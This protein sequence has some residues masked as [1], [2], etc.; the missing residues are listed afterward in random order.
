M[1]KNDDNYTFPFNKKNHALLIAEKPD[2][3]R[4]IEEVYNDH[5]SEISYKISFVSQRGHLLTLLSPDEMDE[6]Q[7]NW[8]WETLPF[9]PEEHGGWKYKVIKEKKTGSFLTSQERF[10]IIKKELSSGKY[11][12][13]INAGD[14]DQ[15]G[16]LL[17][18]IVLSQAENKLPVMRF[19]T[20]DLTESHI[21]NALKNLKNDDKDPMLI[22]LI[23]AAYGRQHSDYRVGMNISRAAT[24][25]MN[26]RVACGRVKTP[27]LAIVCRREDEIENFVP[28][29]SYGVMAYYEDGIT[30]S[31]YDPGASDEEETEDKKGI[32]WFD[33]KKDAENIISKLSKKAKVIFFE[34]KE[35]KTYAPKQFKLATLQIEAGKHGFSDGNTL[36]IVQRLYEKRLLSY[37]RTD[38]EYLSSDENFMGIL[39]VMR[40]IGT[41]GDFVKTIT[42]GDLDRVKKSDKW[43][44]D[45]ALEESGHSAI[46]PTTTVP[47]YSEL[48]ADE[49]YIYEMV[50]KR[51][52]SMF[53]PPLIQ[54]KTTLIT[55]IDGYQFR[56]TGKRLIDIGFEKIFGTSFTDSIMPYKQVDDEM[57]VNEF[58]VS[59]KKLQC[60]KHLT[61]PEIIA[62]CE[63]PAKYLHDKSLKKSL[64]KNLKLGTPATR[65]PIIEQLIE[66]DKYLEVKRE[67]KRDV[68]VPTTLGRMIIKNLGPCDICKIDMTGEWEL[69][70]EDVRCG[71]MDLSI[72]EEQM[73]EYVVRL[74]LDIKNSPMTPFPSKSAIKTVGICPV[75]GKNIIES[76]KGFSCSGYTRDGS[77][78][79]IKLWKSKYN[80]SFDINE[81]MAFWQGKSIEKTVVISGVTMDKELKYDFSQ[82]DIVLADDVRKPVGICPECGATVTL[83]SIDYKCERCDVKGSRFICGAELS[84]DNLKSLLI[85][86]ILAVQ[87]NKDG[88]EWT[89]SLKYDKDKKKIEFYFGEKSGF[90]CPCCKKTTLVDA[91]KY[92]KCSDCKFV[93]WKAA[94]GHVFTSDEINSFMDSGLTP[95]IEFTGKKGPF[96]AK[97][98]LDKKGKKAVF[99]F[100][101]EKK[102]AK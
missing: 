41:I 66:K 44:N 91:E 55:D 49:I 8:R 53:L 95:E 36:R 7:K 89:Q 25:K 15:E 32:I 61:S 69:K 85:G 73:K 92:Y 3:M 39:K 78:C 37:P 21:L 17:I 57:T 62:I 34:E 23:N 9:V 82:N 35:E 81:A 22:N 68:V 2:L 24:L 51:F 4:R 33:D 102:D 6:E 101:K 64:G 80:A 13:V 46:R 65:S 74:I 86:D 67:G 98:K 90:T 28:R 88:K 54:M 94:A 79:N 14:P 5:V 63:N 26:G 48:D 42:K 99:V 31:L 45:K 72:F 100:E 27:I 60:P 10:D 56:S 87:C 75:C 96:K 30:G 76:E 84:A 38:C 47:D 52:V 19:W 83:G 59:E 43:I 97:M 93:F 12:F 77:G 70:L 50:C 29:T 16:E 11:D 40:D 20:N 71:R 18:R 1:F 58:K